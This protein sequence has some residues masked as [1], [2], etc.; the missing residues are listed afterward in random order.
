MRS[1][2]PSRGIRRLTTG[3]SSKNEKILMKERLEVQEE[4]RLGLNCVA[5]SE[6]FLLQ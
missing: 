2:A 1:Q 6:S 4:D 5:K 3:L